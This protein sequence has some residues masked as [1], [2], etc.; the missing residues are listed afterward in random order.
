MTEPE[1]R[2]SAPADLLLTA[3]K[4]RDAVQVLPILGFA[5]LIPP[6]A[7]IFAIDAQILGIPVVVGFIFAVW[8]GL[9]LAAWLAARKLLAA[10][11][12]DARRWPDPTE[13]DPT[14]P[15][16]NA[17]PNRSVPDAAPTSNAPPGAAGRDPP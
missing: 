8:L 5:L 13:P 4:A 2:P 9:I 3:R 10:V 1:R 7:Q 17:A 6:I 15:K 14:E 12:D 16:P 11:D